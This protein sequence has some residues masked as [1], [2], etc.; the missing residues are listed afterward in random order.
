MD[1]DAPLSWDQDEGGLLQMAYNRN[2]ISAKYQ[3]L[4]DTLLDLPA[5]NTVVLSFRGDHLIDETASYR[6]QPERLLHVEEPST[7][8]STL[9]KSEVAAGA[10]DYEI[11]VTSAGNATIRVH[12][13]IDQGPIKTFTTALDSDGRVALHVS[14]GVTKGKYNFLLFNILGQDVWIRAH[15][16]LVVR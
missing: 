8:K 7:H 9:S 5:D 6:S 1:R 4:D 3:S 2:D 15:A 12:Y 16:G 13:T 11:N 14:S 10:D